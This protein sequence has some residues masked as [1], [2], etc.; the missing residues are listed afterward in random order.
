MRILHIITQKPFATGSGVYLSGI[1]AELSKRHEQYLICGLNEAGEA[2]FLK[3]IPDLHLDP[4][5]FNE[6]ELSFPVPGMSDVMPYQSSLYRNLA[7]SQTKTLLKV[8]QLKAERAI[9]A[10]QPDVI[11][12]QHLYL[13]T[14][15]LALVLKAPGSAYRDI[16]MLGICHGSE[17]RQFANTDRWRQQITAGIRLLDCVISTHAEQAEQIRK[18]YGLPEER[19]LI[20]GSG[21]NHR[22]FYFD[23][24]VIKPQDPLRIVYTGKLSRAKGVPE[25]LAACDLVST[26]LNLHLTLIGSGADPD[27]FREILAAAEEKNYPVELTGQLGQTEIADIYRRSHLFVLPSYY[28]GMPLVVPEA[29]A[30]GLKAAVTALPGFEQW[31]N[32]FGDTCALIPQP[33]MKSSDEPTDAG[34]AQF[35]RDIASSILK[36]AQG[37]AV[38]AEPP[39]S[40]MTWEGLAQKIE[41]VFSELAKVQPSKK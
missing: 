13:L 19:I 8:F 9:E 39:V 15:Q 4:V 11:I 26:K 2:D 7:E 6:N 35:I 30:C 37:P 20:L 3:S 28:E 34:R 32:G 40:R 1:M 5:V 17:L 38:T 33:A 10:F 12:C 16:P 21:F 27:E 18:L 31:L 41:G 36:L 22:I 25:L 14:A 29:L 24:L 23:P